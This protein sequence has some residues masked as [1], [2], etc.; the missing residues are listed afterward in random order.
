MIFKKF[1]Y[2]I[3]F[4]LLIIALLTGLGVYILFNTYFWI[5][6]FWIF[7]ADLVFIGV[8]LKFVEKEHKKLSHFLTSVD[9]DDFTPPFS[10][11]YKDLDLNRA[12]E[13]LSGVI[14]SLRDEAQINLQYL[15]TVVNNINTAIICVDES[16]KIVLSNDSAKNLFQKS[17]LRDLD[18][19]YTLKME[20][21]ELLKGLMLDEKKLVKFNQNGKLLN[22]SI[23]LARFK[24]RGNQYRLFSFQDIQSEIEQNELESW[25]K[26][27]RVMTHEIMNS[28]IP[29]SNL[30]GLVYQKVFDKNDKIIQEVDKNDAED[31]RDGLKTIESRSKGL[32]NFVE[33]TRHFT[34]MPEPEFEKIVVTDL[35]SRIGLLL[36]SKIQE[37]SI[38]L[39]TNI[40]SD[41]LSI[42]ADKS[43]IEQALINL[44]LNA[45]D[46]LEE[47]SSPQIKIN[48]SKNKENRILISI[49]DNGKGISEDDLENIF[50]PFYTTKKQGSGIGL[51][52]T[53]Q[54]MFLHKGNITVQSELGKGTKFVISF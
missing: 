48:A 51:S 45:I 34:K 24:I 30:S 6:S 28:V 32:V 5:T 4:Y 13:H 53:K 20:L 38:D 17:M 27:T 15:Q 44:V 3:I 43:L 21:P 22:Y 10:K 1:R 14:V 46:A 35:I 11:D 8:F 50:I 25:Q 12:F 49:E 26:L 33:A 7:I 54:V 37:K 9:Q 39:I 52:L 36:K 16:S 23:Q 41:E 18:S 42:L 47:I 40:E 19:L 29:I 31:I 2:I